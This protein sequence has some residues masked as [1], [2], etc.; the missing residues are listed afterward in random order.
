MLSRLKK[1]F[2]DFRTPIGIFITSRIVVYL[3]VLLAS[4][5]QMGMN[6]S[7]TEWDA[8]NYI[9]IANNGYQFDGT[10]LGASAFIAYFP[11]LPLL[12]SLIHNATGIGYV[13]IGIGASFLF[14]LGAAIL[15]YRL[16]REWANEK[17][18]EAAV[19]LLSFYPMSFY[20]SA[21]YTES[22]FLFF[23]LATLYVMN[24]NKYLHASVCVALSCITRATGSVL[25][26][27]F[28]WDVWKKTRSVSKVILLG[29]LALLPFC[30]FL[31]FQ[32]IVY[33]TPFAFT[34]ALATNWNQHRVWPWVGFWKYIQYMFTD[35]YAFYMWRVEGLFMF[36]VILTLIASF[37]KIPRNVW[38]FGLGVLVLTLMSDRILGM[39]RYMMMVL[40]IFYY[41]GNRLSRHSL[42]LTL[43]VAVSGC[44]MVFNTVLYVFGKLIF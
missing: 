40:P 14:G 16:V 3:T 7:I 29:T 32:Y 1:L 21:I 27:V 12:L 15:L 36:G 18:A 24:K 35:T 6:I 22:F 39:G 19:L 38:Y 37:K 17:A 5:Y 28:A 23:V 31:Y 11:F 42:A 25:G 43:V 44:W 33:G 26:L 9:F 30:S 8:R 4:A 2:I 41:W 20:L 34:E 13:Y 10:F